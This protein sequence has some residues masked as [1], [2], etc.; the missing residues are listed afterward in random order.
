M[1]TTILWFRRD[2]RLADHLALLAA[3]EQADA[4]RVLPVFVADPR[5]LQRAGAARTAALH[6]ALTGLADS[7]EGALL[8][9]HGR[10]EEIIPTLVAETG[11]AAV[12]VT[13]ESTPWGRRR[14]R[15]VA[16][17]LSVPLVETGSPYAVDPGRVTKGDGSPYAVFTP[18]HRAWLDHGWQPPA[19]PPAGLRWHRGGQSEEM[20]A[21]PRPGVGFSWPEVSEHA[22]SQ[23]WQRFLADGVADY[24]DAR[25]RPDLDA[26]SRLSVDLHFGTIHPRTLLAD[27]ATLPRGQRD[28]PGAHRFRAELCW[29]DFYAD[30]LWHHPE[31]AWHDLTTSLAGL[32]WDELSGDAATAFDAWCAGRTGY[33]FVD[34]GLRQL[35][36]EGWMHNR[37][38]MVTAS[39]LVKDLHLWWG[40]GA[41]HFLDHLVDG[42]L[43]SN[44]HGWQWVA[45]TGTDATPYFRVFNPVLQGQR[46]D[47]AGD[48]VRRWVPELRHVPGAAV[49]EPWRVP[50]GHDHGYPARIVDHAA[51]R[52][53]ALARL[54]SIRP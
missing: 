39:F 17:R 24:D 28:A 53:E 14:D 18:F 10:P 19:P 8:V 51:E 9:R 34:A 54:H 45:G 4:G 2:L 35:L 42:D 48:Y 1:P 20:P 30:V 41:R 26:T 38:R 27:L 15:R 52:R 47:P 23:R 49:H 13:A 37:L 43:A 36:A 25:D 29:R 11:A 5:L 46:F 44:N 33:P 6:S 50:G 16:D 40:H 32:P 3:A 12:H 22:A 21:A 7:C 31:S